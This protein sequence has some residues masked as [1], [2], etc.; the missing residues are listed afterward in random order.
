MLNR[1]LIQDYPADTIKHASI[2]LRNIGRFDGTNFQASRFQM[3]A[4]LIANKLT[5]IVYGIKK[6][7]GAISKVASD[8]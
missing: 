5:E 7:E 8:E 2:D 6:R 4:I 3:R 1:L